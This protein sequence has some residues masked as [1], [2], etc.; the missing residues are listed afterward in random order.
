MP[1]KISCCIGLRFPLAHLSV[2]LLM[3]AL[4]HVRFTQLLTDRIE[5]SKANDLLDYSAN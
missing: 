2:C 5:R 4:A 3:G 1:G